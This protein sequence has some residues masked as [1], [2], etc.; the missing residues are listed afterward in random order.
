MIL[1][2]FYWLSEKTLIQEMIITHFVCV[3]LKH[4]PAN[5]L[6]EITQSLSVKAFYLIICLHAV[7][8]PMSIIIR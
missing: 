5:N 1:E 7:Y 3:K 2:G 6:E 8:K 4:K